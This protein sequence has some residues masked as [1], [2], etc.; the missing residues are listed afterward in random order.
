[1]AAGSAAAAAAAQQ[2]QQQQQQEGAA[3]SAQPANVQGGAGQPPPQM[4]ELKVEDALLYLDQVKLE[5]GDRP[6]IYNEFLEIMKN[7][8]AQEIDTPGVIRRVST[9]F[10][11]YNNLI[12]GFN[13][14]LPEGY[15][16][17]LKDLEAGGLAGPPLEPGQ[18]PPSAS[19][20]HMGGGGPGRGGPAGGRGGMGGRGPGPAAGGRGSPY[21][22]PA[23]AAPQ[24]RPQPPP[25]G[26][27]MQQQQPGAM[28]G[29][30]PQGAQQQPPGHA[31]EFDH[32]IAYV[33]TIK[34]RF[35][36]DPRTYQTFLEILHTY[37]KEQRGIKEVLEQV[38][39]LFADHP[40][41]L[42]EF[43][44]FL[45]DAVQE[46]AKERLARAAAEAEERKR[47]MLQAQAAAQAQLY[48]GKKGKKGKGM[49]DPY[50]PPPPPPGHKF[51]DM[52]QPHKVSFFYRRCV[53]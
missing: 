10:R 49:V 39:N 27:H 29:P 32:A 6:R 47:I 43:T 50:H 12:L 40:D 44:F 53:Q 7:F 9:L 17:E 16:I 52:T 2:Q 14:F 4:R 15:K 51:I 30:P 22:T 28:G 46:Q 18:Q 45:P 48:S 26:P 13:T 41:L 19:Q 5:F 20:Q 35:A 34:K 38:S 25:G 37:Q 42:K 8:K 1:M 33:T 24:G 11:G 31:V 3:A 23:R 21:Q 36:N